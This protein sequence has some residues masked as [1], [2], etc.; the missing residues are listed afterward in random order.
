MSLLGEKKKM[1]SSATQSLNRDMAIDTTPREKPIRRSR[2]LRAV[3]PLCETFL[4][5]RVCS[6]EGRR[7]PPYFITTARDV[8]VV[9]FKEAHIWL[10]IPC[11][12]QG[13]HGL[14]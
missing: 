11:G 9:G 3:E 12:V 5:E 13:I 7:R 10:I 4:R 8:A 6:G 1:T 14:H 2:A